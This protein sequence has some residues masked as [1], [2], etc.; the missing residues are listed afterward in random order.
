MEW[1]GRLR[2]RTSKRSSR[3]QELAASEFTRLKA[4]RTSVSTSTSI[5]EVSPAP[6]DVSTRTPRRSAT[7]CHPFETPCPSI[8]AN[9]QQEDELRRRSRDR[10]SESSAGDRDS[11]PHG[12]TA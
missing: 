11:P 5:P 9:S 12:E 2:S 10:Q 7:G 3:R 8:R 1:N 4:P 6:S